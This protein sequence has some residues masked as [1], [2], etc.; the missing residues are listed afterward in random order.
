MIAVKDTKSISFFK[1]EPYFIPTGSTNDFIW[2][3]HTC[4][5]S[6]MCRQKWGLLIFSLHCYV[7]PP[8]LPLIHFAPPPRLLVDFKN[9][10]WLT[11]RTV[12][13]VHQ[14][15]YISISIST[16][17]TQHTIFIIIYT[18]YIHIYICWDCTHVTMNYSSTD[19]NLHPSSE[20]M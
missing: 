18:V 12:L 7:H 1:L 14:P 6:S 9:S 11:L 4:S 13:A 17:P 3:L 19:C 8:D 2:S 5:L 10:K 20:S 16:L 15:F